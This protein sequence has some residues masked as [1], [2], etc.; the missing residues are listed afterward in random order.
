MTAL[1]VIGIIVSIIVLIM[2]IPV[3]ADFEYIGGEI[4]LSALICGFRL[5]I[6]PKSDKA[7]KKPKEKKP[8]KEKPEEAELKKKSRKKDKKPL[9]LCLSAEEVTG[10][11]KKL[12]KGLGRLNFR[13]KRFLLHWVARGTDPYQTAYTFA[14][15]NA[16]LSSLAPLCAEKFSSC[17][18]DVWTDID[19]SDEKMQLDAALA[20]NIRIGCFFRMI[21]TILFGILGIFIRNRCRLL[22]L[23]LSDREYYDYLMEKQGLAGKIIAKIKAKKAA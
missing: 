5:K 8:E 16:V 2:L 17:D 10:I 20:V 13:P 7:E 14:K 18:S 6:L 21:N 19:F 15:A 1:K 11:L 23:K 12:I 22:W 3:G 4:K 9:K